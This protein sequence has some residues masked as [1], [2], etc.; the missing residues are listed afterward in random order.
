[1]KVK[2][3]IELPREIRA[4]GKIATLRRTRKEH[5]CSRCKEPIPAG[6]DYYEVIYAGSGLGGIKFPER[7]HLDCLKSK[8]GEEDGN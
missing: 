6:L 7:F 8:E 2:A 3:G 4:N 1:M 5:C